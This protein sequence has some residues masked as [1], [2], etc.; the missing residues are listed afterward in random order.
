MPRVDV[1]ESLPE[2]VY[3]CSCGGRVRGRRRRADE[4]GRHATVPLACDSDRTPVLMSVV[5][6]RESSSKQNLSVLP[7][8]TLFARR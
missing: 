4:T 7:L 5:S 2:S 1:R 3:V 8:S 6:A